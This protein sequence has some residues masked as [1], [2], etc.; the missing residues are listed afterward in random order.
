MN[1][2]LSEDTSWEIREA[3]QELRLCER[4]VREYEEAGLIG[5][6]HDVEHREMREAARKRLDK[7]LN[8]IGYR[9]QWGDI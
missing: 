7:A 5:T 8:S 2:Y 3:V 4:V 1:Y 9:Y 6:M